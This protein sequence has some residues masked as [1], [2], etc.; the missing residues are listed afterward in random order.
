MRASG[1]LLVACISLLG[2]APAPLPRAE[3]H[4]PAANDVTGRWVFEACE[5]SGVN[6]PQ[7]TYDYR[8]EIT[9]DRLIFHS[10]RGTRTEYELRLYPDDTPAGFTWARGGQVAYVGSY[11]LNRDQLTMIFT[12]GSALENRPK[13][14][15]GKPAWRYVFRRVGR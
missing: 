4:R 12:S 1:L 9:T 11:L 13:D 14:F 15:A 6:D 2:F 7:A 8:V 10:N 5:T 3:R